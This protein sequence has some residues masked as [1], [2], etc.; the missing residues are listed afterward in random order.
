MINLIYENKS[1]SP[2]YENKSILKKIKNIII[3]KLLNVKKKDI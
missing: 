3:N 1:D 2:Y